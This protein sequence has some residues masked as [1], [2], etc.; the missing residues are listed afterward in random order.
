MNPYSIAGWVAFAL[1]AY[2]V[3]NGQPEWAIFWFLVTI[4]SDGVTWLQE[5]VQ[6]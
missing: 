1:T 5:Y 3:Y 4:A 6:E 2:A